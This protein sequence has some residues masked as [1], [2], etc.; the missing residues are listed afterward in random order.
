MKIFIAVCNSQDE[1]PSEFFW[2]FMATYANIPYPA[3]AYRARHPWDV[4]RNNMA[5]DVFLKSECDVFVKMDVDQI[6]PLDYFLKFL[7][8][9]EQYKVIGPVIYDRHEKNGHFPLAFNDK[10]VLTRDLSKE[11]HH[12]TGI[13][14]YPYTHT[15]NFYAREVL[16]MIDPPWYEAHLSADGLERANHVDYDFLDKIKAAGYKPHL[17]LDEVVKHITTK[18][19]GS[20]HYQKWEN[21]SSLLH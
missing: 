10:K 19:V 13:C 6:Y 17:Y 18:G 3:V 2:S 8:L 15:N 7:P 12:G 21:N 11:V 14:A 16:E 4:V 20:E 5:I 1:V 9:V